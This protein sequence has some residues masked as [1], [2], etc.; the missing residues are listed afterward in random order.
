MKKKS[1]PLQVMN[2]Q[3]YDAAEEREQNIVGIRIAEAR[4]QRGYSQA[5]FSEY[6]RDFGV[7]IST[8][9]AGKWETGESVPNAYQMIAICNALGI[10]DQLPY[11]MKEFVPALN[12]EGKHKVEAYKADLIASG[13]YRPT[14]RV[15][16][17]IRYREMR[18]SELRVSA[19]T[20]NFLDEDSFTTVKFPE[21]LVPDGADFGIRVSG[22][23][24]EPAYHDG[25]IVWVQECESVGVGEVGIFIY[26][27]EGYMKMYSEQEPDEDVA[28]EYTDSYGTVHMQP[29]LISFNEAYAPKVIS[30]STIFQVVGRVL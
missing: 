19:G 2:P 15:T 18:L 20:G 4:K 14:P 24:M 11:F 17:L 29:V 13:K 25:Q 28:E 23:S 7:T 16:N 12:E 8:G 3:H 22:D 10:E 26:D 9:G 5:S 30:P 6:L 21:N 27:G 1:T